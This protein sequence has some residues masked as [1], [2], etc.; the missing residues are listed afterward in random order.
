MHNR[1]PQLRRQEHFMTLIR[2]FVMIKKLLHQIIV[3]STLLIILIACFSCTKFFDPPQKYEEYQ[4]IIDTTVKKKVLVIAVDGLVGSQLKTYMP[5]NMGKLLEHSK[6]S[7]ETKSDINTN[8]YASWTTLMTG[9]NSDRHKVTTES[10]MVDINK[11]VEHASYSFTPSLIKRLESMDSK[12]RTMSIVQDPTMSAMIFADADSAVVSA[13]DTKTTE[14]A[15]K[16]L[17]ESRVDL[18]ITQLTGVKKAGENG[19][20]VISN[21]NYKKALDE[22]DSKI[23]TLISSI[24]QRSNYAKEKWLIIITSPQ[25]GTASGSF[26]GRSLDELNTFSLYYNKSFLSDELQTESM[27]FFN[28]TGYYVGTHF[29]Y[30]DILKT[31]PI[32]INMGGTHVQTIPGKDSE[33]F[34]ASNNTSREISYEFKFKLLNQKYWW[35]DFGYVNTSF[36]SKDED[37]TFL[38]KGWSMMAVK[39]LNGNHTFNLSFQNGDTTYTLD[40]DR[41]RNEDW[42]HYAIS[43]KE[44]S[45][46]STAISVFIDGQIKLNKGIPLGLNE[47]ESDSPLTIGYRR[48]SNLVTIPNFNIA[49]F[50][51]WNKAFTTEEVRSVSCLKKIQNNNSYYR[52]LIAYYKDITQNNVWVSELPTVSDLKITGSLNFQYAKNHSL[53]DASKSEVYTQVA[54]VL[55]VV[56]YWFDKKVGNDW[57]L[58][59]KEFLDKYFDEFWRD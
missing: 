26:G 21:P 35:N 15:N 49:D 42:H 38:T 12:L 43:F 22:I 40:F 8:G 51:V 24:E 46:D 16:I 28:A 5:T 6:Y 56:F 50:R 37:D 10:F 23:S 34:N 18:L 57:G 30:D 2:T 7:Y 54:D 44:I 45:N 4:E 20:F 53:C 14:I 59:G 31:D 1:I 13:D 9:V 58:A 11:E 39:L 29:R 3:T 41:G 48:T 19:G 32:V 33:I 17:K 25:G 36:I 52:N 55:P 47:F 27:Q